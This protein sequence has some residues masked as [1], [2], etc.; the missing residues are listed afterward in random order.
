MSSQEIAISFS[1][2]PKETSPFFDRRVGL[3]ELD[4]VDPRHRVDSGCESLSTK[5]FK[6]VLDLANP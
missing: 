1:G 2:K 4:P 6:V 3:L 5:E